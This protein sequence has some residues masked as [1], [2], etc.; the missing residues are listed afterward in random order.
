MNKKTVKDIDLKE[1]TV[2]MRVDFNVPL[3]DNQNITNNLRIQA[4]LPTIQYVLEQKSKLI[5][6]SHLGRPKGKVV[7]S[8]RMAPVGKE[9][10]K[11]L[12]Q[13]V[14]SCNDC[15][16]EEVKQTV[17]Q[18]KPGEIVLLEN[19]RFH[20]EEEKNDAQFAKQLSE[21]AEIYVNDAF[22]TAH[23]AHASTEGITK[24]L[25]AVSGFLMEKELK[26][27]DQALSKP[28]KPYIAIVGG[29]KVSTKIS[30]LENL[31]TKVTGLV[32]GGGMTY[33][34]CKAQG[35]SIGNSLVEED[36]I[37][38]AKKLLQKS[39]ELGV[40]LIIPVDHVVADKFDN[41]ANV[42]IV[43]SNIPEGYMG[44]DIGP[45]S[46][47]TIIELLKKAKTVLWNGPLGVFEMSNFAKGTFEIA[48]VLAEI[49]AVTVVGGG[50]SASAIKK[51][52]ISK[53]KITHI[54]TGGG[55]SV[56][57]IEGKKLPGIEALNDK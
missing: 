38:T 4:A 46:L 9:L 8:M 19:L 33:T 3:D 28:E 30:V 32:I 11:L 7:D 23:R 44:M 40:D 16:G 50:D 39:K 57:F 45:K 2:I 43:E 41:D 56:E 31:M 5:L 36:H 48:K 52:G 24:Y 35:L 20:A 49:D 34:F 18:M 53:D 14:T 21:L 10:A 26:Y 37:D 54:S 17:A 1:K 22:G 12:N 55:A 47:N 25:P 27:L 29:A 13:E 42:K 6:M 51:S 15:I